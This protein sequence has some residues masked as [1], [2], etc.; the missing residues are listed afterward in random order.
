M[1]VGFCL[2]GGSCLAWLVSSVGAL[3]FMGYCSLSLLRALL[4][5]DDVD[6]DVDDAGFRPNPR[7][8]LVGNRQISHP[9]SL[10]FAQ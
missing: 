8:F 5:H 9:P 10:R 6:V 3:F 4:C 7:G 1:L 2:T